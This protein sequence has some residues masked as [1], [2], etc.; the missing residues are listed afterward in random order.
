MGAAGEVVVLDTAVSDG[1]RDEEVGRAGETDNL[2]VSRGYIQ[3]L[4]RWTVS[5]AMVVGQFKDGWLT[6]ILCH[7]FLPQRIETTDGELSDHRGLQTGLKHVLSPGI[8]ALRSYRGD[9]FM[10]LPHKSQT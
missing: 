4:G 6:E 1:Q 2:R 9:G 5:S 7:P 8:P 3:N 10:C